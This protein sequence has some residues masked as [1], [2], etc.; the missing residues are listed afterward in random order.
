MT[1]I[2]ISLK[3]LVESEWIVPHIIALKSK[4][5]E[6]EGHSQAVTMSEI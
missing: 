4:V 2:Q 6:R 3:R 5:P 1:L